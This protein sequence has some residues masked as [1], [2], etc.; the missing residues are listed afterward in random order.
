VS[1]GQ[2]QHGRLTTLHE[3]ARHREHEVGV[4]AEHSVQELVRHVFRDLG[5][6]LSEWRAAAGCLAFVEGVRQLRPEPD[7]LRRHGRDDAIGRP[8]DEIPKDNAELSTFR[9]GTNL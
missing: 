3:V 2:D 8:L 1:S 7:G 5:A 4:A 6:P 9:F